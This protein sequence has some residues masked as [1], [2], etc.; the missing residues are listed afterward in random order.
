MVK[1]FYLVIS[2][3]KTVRTTMNPPQLGWAELAIKVKLD[4]PDK[5]FVMPALQADITIPED[6]V[7]TRIMTPEVTNNIKEA[8]E[9]VTGMEIKLTV[10]DPKEDK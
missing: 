1:L 7:K 8:L 4:I 10:I 3:R 2:K 6:A 5:L 9:G